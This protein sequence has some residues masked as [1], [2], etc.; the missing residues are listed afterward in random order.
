MS[1]RFFMKQAHYR[2]TLDISNEAL[3]AAD[4]GYKRLMI[5]IVLLEKIKASNKNSSDFD[6]LTLKKRCYRA[7]ADDFNTPV[8]IAELF[9]VVRFINAVYD[10]KM[11]IDQTML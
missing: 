5:A 11:T 4:K 2:S 1:V 8:L 6:L 10:G 3:D 7:M 9:E